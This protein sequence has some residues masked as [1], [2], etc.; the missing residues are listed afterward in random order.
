MIGKIRSRLH[1][2]MLAGLCV[3]IGGSHPRLSPT[4]LR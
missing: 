4:A 1:R 3:L 2:R